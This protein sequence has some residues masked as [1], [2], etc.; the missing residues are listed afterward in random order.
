MDPGA[1][2]LSADTA[3]SRRPR[4][5]QSLLYACD[6]TPIVRHTYQRHTHIDIEYPMTSCYM[7]A[8][9]TSENLG[10]RLP[11]QQTMPIYS[12]HRDLPCAR[13]A[14]AGTSER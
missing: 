13:H 2:Y 10:L 4:K 6:L 7:N 9:V 11:R 1:V 3:I 5:R 8:M 12:W 14:P